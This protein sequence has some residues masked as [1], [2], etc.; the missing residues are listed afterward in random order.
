MSQRVDS[1]PLSN[2]SCRT[3]LG[4]VP[5][6]ENNDVMNQKPDVRFCRLAICY[7]AA[8]VVWRFSIV[9]SFAWLR[10]GNFDIARLISKSQKK[11]KYAS[12][13]L[14]YLCRLP[15]GLCGQSAHAHAS[16]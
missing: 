11:E 12:S 8:F 6:D 10:I 2:N 5:S 14:V 15:R 9:I 13:H 16:L 3:R 1:H 7:S 4:E